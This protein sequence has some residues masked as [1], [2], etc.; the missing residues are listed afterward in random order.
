MSE[1]PPRVRWLAWALGIFPLGLFIG[2]VVALWWN[3]H[4]EK[5]REALEHQRYA[6]EVSE[7]LMA[8]DVKK[9]IEVIGERN[10]SSETTSQNLSRTL[11]MIEGLLGPSNTGYTVHR[12]RGPAQWPLLSVV[13]TGKNPG[14]APVWVVTSCDS[15]TG[16]PGSEANATGMA[17]TIA[18]A[19][20]LAREK[21]NRPLHF[22]FLPHSNDSNSPVIDTA[23]A[24]KKLIESGPTPAAV[25]CVEAMGAGNSLWLSSRDTASLPLSRYQDLGSVYGAEILCLGDDVDLSSTLFEMNLPAVRIATRAMVSPEEADEKL[26]DIQ[27]LTTSTGRLIEL[28]RRCLR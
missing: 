7:S 25:L 14:A 6:H 8:D 4:S 16:S 10:P 13:V 9:F 26:P 21:P 18:A 3:F 1:S 17:A 28:I 24:L 12:H 27:K 20:S 15:R 22:V 19:Q 2:G 11:S 5:E 23:A